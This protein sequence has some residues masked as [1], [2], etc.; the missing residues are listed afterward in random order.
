MSLSRRRFL[1]LS[2][3]AISVSMLPAA[4][5]A[6]KNEGYP[7]L[8]IPPLLESHFGQPLFLTL[9]KSYW[10]FDGSHPPIPKRNATK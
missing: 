1:K 6:E 5:R 4:V 3:I 8:P 2:S 7:L 10:S 9:K